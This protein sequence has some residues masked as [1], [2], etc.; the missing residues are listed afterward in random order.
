MST[1]QMCTFTV[2]KLLLGVDVLSV[3]EVI[4]HH[5]MTTVPLAPTVVRGLIN[6]R[7]QIVMAI[8]LRHRLGLPERGD[9]T[10]SMN[11]VVRT[12]EGPISLLVDEIGDVIEVPVGEFEP[13]P[14]T[15]SGPARA[16]VDG[17]Y[18]LHEQLLL[19]L[20]VG[21]AVQIGA[22]AA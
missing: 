15:F 10:M 21:A 2:D 11:V 1:L 9:D 7:G 5:A 16:L 22:A 3:Q 18:K 17:V 20:D 14:R 19:V 12:D 4:R 13:P 8:D 6:L